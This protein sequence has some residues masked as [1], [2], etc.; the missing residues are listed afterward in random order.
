MPLS[1]Y[2]RKLYALLQVLTDYEFS[3]DGLSQLACFQDENTDVLAELDQWWQAQ[4]GAG[5]S[6]DIAASSDRVNLHACGSSSEGE[7]AEIPIRHPISGQVGKVGSMQSLSLEQIPDEIRQESDAQKVFWWFW[8]FF[9]ELGLKAQSGE[10]SD[11]LL[12]PAHLVLPDCPLHSYQATVSALTGPAFRK[13][14]QRR[15]LLPILT[16]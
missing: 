6:K 2:Q 14:G 9:P 13:I 4:N 11:G 8:R 5:L 7:G 3:L 15:K 10:L 12:Y 1:V 16:C